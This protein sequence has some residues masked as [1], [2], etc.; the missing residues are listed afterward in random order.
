VKEKLWDV[1]SDEEIPFSYAT[2]FLWWFKQPQEKGG[3]DSNEWR[4][5]AAPLL[6]INGI[7]ADERLFHENEPSGKHDQNS[8]PFLKVGMKAIDH[9]TEMSIRFCIDGVRYK[10]QKEFRVDV[11]PGTFRGFP[12]KRFMEHIR[13]LKN[14]VIAEVAPALQRFKENPVW[15][16]ALRGF[17]ICKKFCLMMA[18]FGALLLKKNV[19]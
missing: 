5:Q 19:F 18:R 6:C 4:N 13:D 12:V 14:S 10:L 7:N 2:F 16:E 1:L 17:E 11:L 9:C 8:H 3:Q 15:D